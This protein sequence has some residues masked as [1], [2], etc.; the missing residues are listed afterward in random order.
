ISSLTGTSN[1][2]WQ[3]STDGS[4]WLAVGTVSPSSALLLASTDWLRFVPNSGFNGSADVR[5]RAWD[6]THGMA[7][8][9][10][11]L[12]SSTLGDSLS[13]SDLTAPVWTNTAPV[14]STS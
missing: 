1:G 5:F 14:L 13:L 3:Y 6:Q 10:V 11:S 12:T 7:H 9:R 2:V 4:N 8:G